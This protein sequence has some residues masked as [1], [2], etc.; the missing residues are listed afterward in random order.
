MSWTP[1]QHEDYDALKGYDVY[2]SDNEKIGTVR[3]IF[4]PQEDITTAVGRHYFRVEPGTLEGLF[5]D[6]DEVFVPEGLVQRVDPE[7]E[8]VILEVP[9]SQ[10]NEHEF[11]RPADIDSFR[12]S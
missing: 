1:Q 4:H 5:K 6:V 10:L 8:S 11:G 3:E 2:S 7:N 12:S 9:K